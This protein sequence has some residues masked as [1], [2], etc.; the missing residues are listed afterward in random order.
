LPFVGLS[1]RAQAALLAATQ[2]SGAW[3]A[4]TVTDRELNGAIVSEQQPET[5]SFWGRHPLEMFDC[6]FY[7]MSL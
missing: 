3:H 2:V 7:L 1:T 4:A 6:F 5:G